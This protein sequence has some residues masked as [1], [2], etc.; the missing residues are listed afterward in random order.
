[1]YGK[2]TGRMAMADAIFELDN[3]T[4]D[5]VPKSINVEE[6]TSEGTVIANG[7][8]PTSSRHGIEY[9]NLQP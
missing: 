9:L 5:W 3:E 1:M 4:G 2:D 7:E 6:L 8:V